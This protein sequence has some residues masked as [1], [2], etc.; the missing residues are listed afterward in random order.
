MSSNIKKEAIGGRSCDLL[1]QLDCSR[2][3]KQRPP[4]WIRVYESGCPESRQFRSA[5][6]GEGLVVLRFS[7]RC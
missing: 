7:G 3:Q 5:A 6:Q 4:E 1:L 2:N